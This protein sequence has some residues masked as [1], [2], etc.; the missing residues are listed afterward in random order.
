MAGSSASSDRRCRSTAPY[1]YATLTGNLKTSIDFLAS[2]P[3]YHHWDFSAKV[4]ELFRDEADSTDWSAAAGQLYEV[5]M[6]KG[7]W[8]SSCA[9]SGQVS[10]GETRSAYIIGG[11]GGKRNFQRLIEAHVFPAFAEPRVP[12]N[13]IELAPAYHEAFDKFDFHFLIDEQIVLIRLAAEHMYFSKLLQESKATETKT[14]DTERASKRSK[15]A[16]S[17][18]SFDI[19]YKRLEREPLICTMYKTD[20]ASQNFPFIIPVTPDEDNPPQTYSAFR[21]DDDKVLPKISSLPPLPPFVLPAS[22]NA[23][24]FAMA[25]RTHQFSPA[26]AEVEGR[27]QKLATLISLLLKFWFMETHLSFDLEAHL[28]KTA[29]FVKDTFPSSPYAKFFD[30]SLRKGQHMLGKKVER[31]GP[32]EETEAGTGLTAADSKMAGG[33]EGQVSAS[34]LSLAHAR[35]R[36]AW[37]TMSGFLAPPVPTGAPDPTANDHPFDPLLSL[38]SSF[39]SNGFNSGLPHG[40]LHGL[41][42]GRELGREK[43]WEIW[44]EIGYLEGS[45]RFW[46]EVCKRNGKGGRPAQNLEQ[47][48]QLV[49]S[50]PTSNDSS[51]LPQPDII[52][53]SDP[54]PADPTSSTSLL[55]A[56]SPSDS[57]LDIPSLLSSLRSKY[58]TACASL[59]VRP[60]MAV[61]SAETSRQT[62]ANGDGLEGVREASLVV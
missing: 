62:Q 22:S 4:V 15:P 52:P 16:F 47:L 23:M 7:T 19:L 17:R 29:A 58:R 60:R 41:I 21:T 6:L 54:I 36:D 24:I 39:Y 11:R 28:D 34:G 46:S 8:Q 32:Q 13:R 53:P 49:N 44:E 12:S 61:A 43:A 2:L 38:E 59:G 51:S 5:D 25:G 3:P 27:S 9:L 31:I 40:E 37:Y 26:P 1:E 10:G 57:D 35:R 48:L 14:G 42:E 20:H 18:P 30:S 33:D 50:F 55:S 56:K 45:G